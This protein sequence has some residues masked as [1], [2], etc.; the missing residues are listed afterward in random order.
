MI[1][2]VP[3]KINLNGTPLGVKSLSVTGD[4]AATAEK[5]FAT[6]SLPVSG[7][8]GVV[9]KCISKQKTSYIDEISRLTDEKYIITVTENE[10][11]IEASCEKAYSVPHIRLQSSLKTTNLKR[12]SLKIIPFSKR[13]DISKA[14][15][16]TPGKTA[17]V[18]P[19]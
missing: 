19:L 1:Y 16:A 9:I 6:Y 4:F 2:P 15:T 8:Y 17:S 7:G 13:E 5:V 18:F 3:Q 14:F 11:V 10:A 12:A